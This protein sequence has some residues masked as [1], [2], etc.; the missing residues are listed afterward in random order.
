MVYLLRNVLLSNHLTVWHG[1]RL[2]IEIVSLCSG[3]A[4]LALFSVYVLIGQSGQEVGRGGEE[5]SRFDW[6]RVISFKICLLVS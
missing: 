3:V 1:E 6:K 4:S 2:L 5:I